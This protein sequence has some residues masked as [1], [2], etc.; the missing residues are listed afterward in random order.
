MNRY[1]D[2]LI[3][4]LEELEVKCAALEADAERLD[5]LEKV[6]DG[7]HNIDRISA[8]VGDGF[9]VK[10]RQKYESLRAAIDAAREV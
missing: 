2:Q 6:E 4:R 3:E 8:V 7:F 9:I 1:E 5:W 10:R